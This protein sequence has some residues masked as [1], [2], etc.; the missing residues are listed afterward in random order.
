[1]VCMVPWIDWMMGKG[2][3]KQ[4]R[5]GALPPV[6]CDVARQTDSALV[7]AV[8]VLCVCVCEWVCV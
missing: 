1:M 3:C 5:D 4:E 8:R 7:W 6:W 2:K